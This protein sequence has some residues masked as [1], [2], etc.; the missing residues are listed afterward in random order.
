MDVRA[1]APP[2]DAPEVVGN[3][4]EA[5]VEAQAT[6]K[7]DRYRESLRTATILASHRAVMAT[8]EEATEPS[9]PSR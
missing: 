3:Q 9:E 2:P 8:A 5:P 4:P 7:Q 1:E 6:K